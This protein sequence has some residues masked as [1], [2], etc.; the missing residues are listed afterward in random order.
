MPGCSSYFPTEKEFDLGGYEVYW[1]LLVIAPIMIECFR[2]RG[3][4]QQN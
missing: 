1:S 3:I 4:R 2:Y